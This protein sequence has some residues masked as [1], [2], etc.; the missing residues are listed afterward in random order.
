MS[1]YRRG[2]FVHNGKSCITVE[3]A[4]QNNRYSHL[5]SLAG[6]DGQFL[7]RR[8]CQ[9]FA[10]ECLEIAGPVKLKKSATKK[11]EELRKEI[12]DPL[13]Q[14][15]LSA[16]RETMKAA[17]RSKFQGPQTLSRKAKK[18]LLS[19]GDYPIIKIVNK[20]ECFD[21][22]KVPDPRFR[23]MRVGMNMVG[24][25]LEELRVE[26]RAAEVNETSND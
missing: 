10:E 25:I 4:Y 12:P 7:A 20:Y 14:E 16:R 17:F 23:N 21:W 2:Y 22:A 13:F 19:I 1:N 8:K 26:F 24:K 3:H 15:W 18:V 9:R 11:K 6:R 5:A